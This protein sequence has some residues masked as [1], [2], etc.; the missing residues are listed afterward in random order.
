[1]PLFLRVNQSTNEIVAS[2]N[3]PSDSCVPA[4]AGFSTVQVT[5]DMVDLYAA[6]PAGQKA[7]W[8]DNGVQ[9]Q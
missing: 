3:A 4:E 8:G 2:Y 1:V 7:M 5:I 6:T 9:Y